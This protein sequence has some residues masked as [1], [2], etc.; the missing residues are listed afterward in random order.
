MNGKAKC[1]I[2]KDIRRR[3]AEE[4]DIAYVTS[5][6]KH[7]GNCLG[8]CPKCEA[9]VRYLE[10]QLEAKRRAG[11]AVALAGLALTVTTATASCVPNA[12]GGTITTVTQEDTSLPTEE[13]ATVDTTEESDT[14]LD[15]TIASDTTPLGDLGG[16]PVIWETEMGELAIPEIEI[17]FHYSDT[18][19]DSYISGYSREQIRAAWEAD[20]ISETDHE[21]LFEIFYN[22]TSY[23]VTVVYAANG[24]AKS[25]T[26]EEEILMGD[27]P[28]ISYPEESGSTEILTEES[29]EINLPPDQVT[30]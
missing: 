20:L 21:D 7:K 11:Y 29:E 4:N 8:T 27:I 19:K 9:E 24:M 10:E 25:I 17:L 22:G 26:T 23:F 15:S 30:E 6:C 28:P 5:E 18:E 1:K 13:S 3:I 14:I 12:Q 2:L 16:D